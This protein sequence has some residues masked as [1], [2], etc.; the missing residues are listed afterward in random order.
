MGVGGGG[1]LE[2]RRDFFSPGKMAILT[3]LSKR[4]EITEPFTEMFFQDISKVISGQ[5]Y[6]L[7]RK[8]FFSQHY[9]IDKNSKTV[10]GTQY[11]FSR[12]VYGAQEIDVNTSAFILFILDHRFHPRVPSRPTLSQ[13]RALKS[14]RRLQQTPNGLIL[15]GCFVSQKKTF[16]TMAVNSLCSGCFPCFIYKKAYH[17]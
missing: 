9:Q 3:L 6:K 8:I 13:F 7:V 1:A 2:S 12:S 5:R 17:K 14:V 15:M 11:M 4:E 16:R 10:L